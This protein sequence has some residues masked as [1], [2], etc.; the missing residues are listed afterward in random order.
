MTD[1]K[2]ILQTFTRFRHRQIRKPLSVTSC[3]VQRSFDESEGVATRRC[4]LAY[5]SGY[6]GLLFL[7]GPSFQALSKTVFGFSPS[8]ALVWVITA[9]PALVLG[10]AAGMLLDWQKE[11]TGRV[12]AVIGF[13]LGLIG[14]LVLSFWL[15]VAWGLR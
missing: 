1:V 12:P 14:S 5:L 6:L 15:E 9:P 11:L 10:L 8:L 13:T 7:F 2:L 4:G 3:V